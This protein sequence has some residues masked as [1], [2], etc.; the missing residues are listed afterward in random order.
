MSLPLLRC[1]CGE[2]PKL[3]EKSHR[4]F[5]VICYG[6]SHT[7]VACL[8]TSGW[9]GDESTASWKWNRSRL[10]DVPDYPRYR[11]GDEETSRLAAELIG[12]SLGKI[13][14]LVIGAFAQH[15]PMTA[16]TAELLPEFSSYGYSTIRKRVSELSKSGLL[17]KSGIDKSGRTPR[18][19]YE[20][21]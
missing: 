1:A 17:G 4:G 14:L 16:R 5:A 13:Q 10:K 12:K 20:L 3:V 2:A 18:T 15:G 11:R 6:P 7:S 9:W 19:I 8:P 21:A